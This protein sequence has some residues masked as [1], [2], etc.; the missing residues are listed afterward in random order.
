VA[1]Q[2]KMP[3]VATADTPGTGIGTAAE[4]GT[5]AEALAMLREELAQDEGAGRQ[6]RL[7]ITEGDGSRPPCPRQ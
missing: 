6:F 2:K 3:V 7:E 5:L 1:T 4:P